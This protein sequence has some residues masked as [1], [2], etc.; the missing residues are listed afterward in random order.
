MIRA[1]LALAGATQIQLAHES[2][3]RYDRLV[4]LLGGFREPRPAEVE[5]IG[6]AL[7][8]LTARRGL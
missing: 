4:K 7:G 3:I 2:G 6:A 5:A 8:R 1:Q